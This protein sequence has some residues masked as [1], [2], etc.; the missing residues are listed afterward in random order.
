[1]SIE[2]AEYARDLLRKIDWSP[3]AIEGKVI[4]ERDDEAA[5]L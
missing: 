1:V 4:S 3:I 5:E 2:Q